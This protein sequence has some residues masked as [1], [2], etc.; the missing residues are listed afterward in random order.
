MRKGPK[1]KV[2]SHINTETG[3]H[4]L[5]NKKKYL[6]PEQAIAEADR[7]NKLPKQIHKL[8]PYK[9]TTCHFFHIGRAG[10]LNP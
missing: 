5:K 3:E 8:L 2:F 10:E 7:L 4:I 9:C 6:K 1:C